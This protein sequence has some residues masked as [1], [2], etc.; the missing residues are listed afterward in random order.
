MSYSPFLCH[1]ESAEETNKYRRD[2][3]GFIIRDEHVMIHLDPISRSIFHN[4]II[5]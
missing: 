2:E 1:V 5:L 3:C 4:C